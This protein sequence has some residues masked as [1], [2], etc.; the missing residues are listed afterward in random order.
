MQD[1]EKYRTYSRSGAPVSEPK[2]KK[3][4][5]RKKAAKKKAAKK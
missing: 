1:I 4:V 5:A 2:A 3:A